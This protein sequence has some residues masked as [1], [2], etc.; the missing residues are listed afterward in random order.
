[1]RIMPGGA[2]VTVPFSPAQVD[3]LNGYQRS[4]AGHSFTCGKDACRAGKENPA[5]WCAVLRA[6]EDG[7][8]CDYCGYTQNWAWRFMADL[9][10]QQPGGWSLIVFTG[11]HGDIPLPGPG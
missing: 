1:V 8:H 4:G 5:S 6:A 7:W 10:W 9:S 2:V 11:V 3:S